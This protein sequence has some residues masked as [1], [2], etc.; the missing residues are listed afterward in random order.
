[1]DKERAYTE[2]Y[3]LMYSKDYE[4]LPHSKRWEQI[5]EVLKLLSDQRFQDGKKSGKTEI[6]NALNKLIK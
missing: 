3:S 2:I 6:I 4:N 5:M 1:M